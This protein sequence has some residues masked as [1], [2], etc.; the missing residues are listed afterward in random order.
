MNTQI[1]FLGIQAFIAIVE[2]GSFQLAA[3][4]L[5]LSQT[6]ISHRMRKLE[7]SLGVKLVART[8]RGIA[9][10]D[11]GRALLP[12]ARSAVHELALSCETVRKH[13]QNA[14]DWLAF[15]CLPTVAAGIMT[16]LLQACR[17]QWPDTPV[18]VFD[19]SIP[20]ITELVESRTAAFGI[21][22]LQSGR[23]ELAVE[24]IADEL[25]VVVCAASH[26]LARA[27]ARP[28]RWADLQDE[29]LIRISL[30][31]G[32]SMTID[33]ALGPLRD[34]LRWR[35][36]AQHN[37]M[38]LDMVRGGLGLTV[39]PRLSVPAD[40]GLCALAIEA[41]AVTRTL[42]VVTRRDAVLDARDAWVRDRAVALVRERLAPGANAA[43]A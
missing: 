39:V 17:T 1:D 42:C 27:A 21:T 32:N 4:E 25:F 35:Y 19:S 2:H 13:G 10:T 30:P 18:R 23:A 38:A 43:L 8:T 3:T 37:G 29:P 6:A 33:D 36:E 12:R 16:P 24:R 5:H 28:V 15:A 11:A 14:V 26:H 40:A 41:P 7:E 9:L 22:V 34:Q 31:S 20:E